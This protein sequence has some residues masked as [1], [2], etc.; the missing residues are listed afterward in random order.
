M[1]DIEEILKTNK[2]TIEIQ[3]STIKGLHETITKYEQM[4]REIIDQTKEESKE[5]KKQI[6]ENLTVPFLR[7]I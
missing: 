7:V 1:V 2:E 5:L 3:K 6:E 4:M